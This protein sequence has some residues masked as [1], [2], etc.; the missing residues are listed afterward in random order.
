M[1]VRAFD[2]TVKNPVERSSF[3]VLSIDI[4]EVQNIS[5]SHLAFSLVAART[6][7]REFLTTAPMPTSL[8]S[9][10]ITVATL[11]LKNCGLDGGDHLLSLAFW[12]RGGSETASKFRVAPIKKKNKNKKINK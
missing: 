3:R 4:A 12:K 11:T 10:K 1:G 6:S 2:L 8:L 5:P 9:L 7:P